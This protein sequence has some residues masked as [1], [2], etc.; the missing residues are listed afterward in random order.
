[1]TTGKTSPTARPVLMLPPNASDTAP[2]A[3]GPAV[4]PRSP[5]S[6]SRANMAV[7]PLGHPALA[8]L[9]TPGHMMPTKKPTKPHPASPSA[10]TGE[11]THRAYPPAQPTAHAIS[12]GRRLSFEPKAEYRTRDNPIHT[13]KRQGPSRSPI[14]LETPKPSSAKADAHC[15]TASSQLPAQTI[16]SAK[17]QKIFVPNNFRTVMPCPSSTRGKMGTKR[18]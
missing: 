12:A 17:S 18:K 2:T 13:A 4:Q 3:D 1:M 16:K 10:G 6:A 11:K 14:V 9:N 5:A 8:M 15:A 7:P